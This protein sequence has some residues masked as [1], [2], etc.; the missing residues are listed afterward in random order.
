MKLLVVVDMVNGFVNQG[1]LADKKI[2]KITPVIVN[3]VKNAISKNLPIIAFK[4][5]HEVDDIEFETYPPHCI[6][7]TKECDLIPEL[8]QYEN[9]MKLIEKNTT[10]GFEVEEFRK[11]VKAYNFKEVVI[12][13]CCTDICVEALATSLKY[14]YIKTNKQTKITVVENAV[15]TFDSPTHDAEK[16]HN[17]AL[18]RLAILGVN[19]QKTKKNNYESVK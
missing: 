9:S 10:N 12:V 6:K 7:G 2:N 18:N 19:L 4:D 8:K 5:T 17:N 1:A 13:G 14:Y 11:I 15:Y 16:T 3:I